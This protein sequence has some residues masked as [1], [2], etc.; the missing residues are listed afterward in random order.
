MTEEDY[1]RVTYSFTS[2][3]ANVL[4][5]RNPNMTFVFVSGQGADST[6]RGRLMWARVKGKTEN[7]V[8]RLPIRAAYVFRPAM[9]QA[10]HGITSRTK[11]YRRMYTVIGPVMPLLRAAFPKAIT[12]TEQIGRAMI[13]VA[14]SG[15][16]KK[17][18][19]NPDINAI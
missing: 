19:E 5:K 15:A 4:A 2:A 9:I 17:I 11:L 14:R 13:K 7:A 6:E 3:A 16:P 8:L 12:T 18:L 10:L 1:T